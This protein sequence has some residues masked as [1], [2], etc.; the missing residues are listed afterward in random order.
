MDLNQLILETRTI[1]RFEQK[2]I[3]SKILREMIENARISPSAANAQPLRYVVVSKK[4]LVE[5]IQPLVHWAAALPKELGTPKIG[6]QPVAFVTVSKIPNANSFSDIDV[7]LAA[8]N[9]ILTARNH[10]IGACIMASIDREK[11]KSILGIAEDLRIVI[12]LGYP[13]HESHI[14]EVDKSREKPLNYFLDD[15]KNYFVP[16]RSFDEI[17]RMEVD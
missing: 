3:D 10:G 13:A 15:Q 16:K 8:Q 11:I 9:M 7:G 6:E 12:A 14:V 1:R 2:P 4:D 5:K 17:C